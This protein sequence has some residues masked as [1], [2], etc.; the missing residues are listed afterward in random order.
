MIV[1]ST[2]I[3]PRLPAGIELSVVENVGNE[4]IRKG[5][6]KSLSAEN[7]NVADPEASITPE[8]PELFKEQKRVYNKKH[9]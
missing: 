6:A 2:N 8:A 3:H 5:Y 9:K 1:V 4:M 7:E